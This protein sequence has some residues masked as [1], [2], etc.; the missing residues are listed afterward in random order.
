MN[1]LVSSLRPAGL[2]ALPALL[3]A[4]SWAPLLDQ[5][6]QFDPLQFHA[7]QER[8]RALPDERR[9]EL[10][11]RWSTFSLLPEAERETA[12]QRMEIVRGMAPPLRRILGRPP[13]QSELALQLDLLGRPLA[14]CLAAMLGLPETTKPEALHAAAEAEVRARI[15]SFLD[16]LVAAGSTTVGE[17]DR[18]LGQSL[19][20]VIRDGLLR[21]AA[22]PEV[23]A[24]A[25]GEA[26]LEETV[27][28]MEREVLENARAPEVRGVPGKARGAGADPVRLRLF[29]MAWVVTQL[30]AK[31]FTPAEIQDVLRE[32]ME[33]LDRRIADELASR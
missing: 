17:R 10:R 28:K 21:L 24:P 9:D 30:K 5:P 18:L 23:G 31:G 19:S 20:L 12:V 16:S 27:L 3:L 29:K 1:S 15:T 11:S 7:N 25:G 26:S 33:S 22:A 4:A 13:Q 8:W 14:K 2:L 32:P 6:Q